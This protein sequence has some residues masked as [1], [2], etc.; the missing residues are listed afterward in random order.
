MVF[1]GYIA[2]GGHL[3]IDPAKIDVIVKW[4]RPHNVTEVMSLIS[5]V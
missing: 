4:A 3:K 2:G 5:A 1:L